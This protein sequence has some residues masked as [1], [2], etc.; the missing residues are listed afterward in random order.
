MLSSP[1][2]APL[3]LSSLAAFVG[4]VGLIMVAVRSDWSQK[5]A[6]VF[7]L[8]A[9]G[10]LLTMVIAHLAPEALAGN[11]QAPLFILGGFFLGLF[12]HDIL[13]MILPVS[14]AKALAAGLT[15][16]I[17]IGIHSFLDGMIYTVT[18]TVG[19]DTGVLS[20]LGLVLHEFP[21]AIITFALLRGAGISNRLSFILAL[22]AASLTTPLGT[23]VAIPL[24]RTADASLLPIFFAISAGLLLFVSTGPLMAHMRDEHPIRSVPALAFGVILA[25]IILNSAAGHG[26]MPHDSEEVGHVH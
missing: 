5:Y 15:P 7:A 14:D 19:F 21:E 25:L 3:F 11:E 1:L 23:I 8:I 2:L 20:T 18:F 22:F 9:S 6:S 4:A 24:I 26:H 13:R 17:A 12:V 10:L 16:L